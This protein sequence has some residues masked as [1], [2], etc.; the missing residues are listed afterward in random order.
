[1]ATTAGEK[2]VVVDLVIGSGSRAVEYSSGCSFDG[3]DNGLVVGIGEYVASKTIVLPAKVFG[4]VETSA[5]LESISK[6]LSIVD[7]VDL[8]N[9]LAATPSLGRRG[10]MHSRPFSLC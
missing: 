10:H 4:V 8:M 6:P 9:I 5:D 3:N 7:F 2:E 1:L